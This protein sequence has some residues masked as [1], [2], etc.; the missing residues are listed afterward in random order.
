M[1]LPALLFL[2]SR[3]HL[4]RGPAVGGAAVAGWRQN[5]R[6]QQIP[7]FIFPHQKK[8]AQMKD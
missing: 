8:K 7:V 1:G 6:F 2:R 4:F 5:L 3:D